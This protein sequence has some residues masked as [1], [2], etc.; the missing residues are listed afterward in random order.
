[1]GKDSAG[2]I[3]KTKGDKKGRTYHNKGMIN[4]KVPVY[5]LSDNLKPSENVILC[6]A[7]SLKIIGFID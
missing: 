2:Y 3:V 1:M 7:D 4:G 5:L 6:S